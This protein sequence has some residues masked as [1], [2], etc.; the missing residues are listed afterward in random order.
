MALLYGPKAIAE[1]LNV[2]VPQVLAW[3]DSN[4]GGT[5]AACAT[6]LSIPIEAVYW[7]VSRSPG[8]QMVAASDSE[9][10]PRGEGRH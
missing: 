2:T 5:A 10:M 7:A 8:Y 1:T 6:A 4:P 3:I 9:Y